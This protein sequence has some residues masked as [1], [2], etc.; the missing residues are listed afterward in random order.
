MNTSHHPHSRQVVTPSRHLNTSCIFLII[1]YIKESGGFMA[2]SRR[3]LLRVLPHS[4]YRYRIDC[5]NPC[6]LSGRFP[7]LRVPLVGDRCGRGRG[8]RWYWGLYCGV[9]YWL[10]CMCSICISTIIK[11]SGGDHRLSTVLY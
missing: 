5:R 7:C 6:G 11:Y 4:T 2:R 10:L 1:F 8:V 3:P 9:T